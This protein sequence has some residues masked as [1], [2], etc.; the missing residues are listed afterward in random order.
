MLD[1]SPR[2]RPT[3]RALTAGDE[4]FAPARS[5]GEATCPAG[6]PV[7]RREAGRDGADVWVLQCGGGDVKGDETWKGKNR[8]AA[9]RGDRVEMATRIK[10][11]VHMGEADAIGAHEVE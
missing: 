10:N 5:A 7:G 3:Q 6:E 4:D 9:S 11:P 1:Q 2:E 8:I